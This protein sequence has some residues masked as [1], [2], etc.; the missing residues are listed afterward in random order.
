MRTLKCA[1]ITVYLP[2]LDT[3]H[4]IYEVSI[5]VREPYLHKCPYYYVSNI[6]NQTAA[7]TTLEYS[8]SVDGVCY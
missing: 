7:V 4:E 6:V 3:S 5:C 1:V 2:T 8:Y